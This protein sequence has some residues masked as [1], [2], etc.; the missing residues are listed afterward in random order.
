[1]TDWEKEARIGM[2]FAKAT[3]SRGATENADRLA[4][5]SIALTNIAI[6]E[7]LRNIQT[8]IEDQKGEG[9]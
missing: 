2:D 6:L 3:L 1:M 8:A 4:L 9:T 7:E 5:F